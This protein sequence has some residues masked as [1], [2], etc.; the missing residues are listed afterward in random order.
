MDSVFIGICNFLLSKCIIFKLVGLILSTII[1]ISPVM[2]VHYSC[3]RHQA[4]VV[5]T[6]S[7]D[8]TGN[9]LTN[10]IKSS[11]CSVFQGDGRSR[12]HPSVSMRKPS[13]LIQLED[14]I[15]SMM[16]FFFFLHFCC[17][18]LSTSTSLC[19]LY[20]VCVVVL[21]VNLHTENCVIKPKC[22]PLEWP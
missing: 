6:L 12:K 10:K 13:N 18:K 16:H 5:M 8:K 22:Q 17:T 4:W 14:V 3:G 11:Y 9:D 2:H 19:I 21:G 1:F 7:M 15:Y 20:I